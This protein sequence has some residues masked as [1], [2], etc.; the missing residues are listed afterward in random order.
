MPDPNLNARMKCIP[1][2]LW[3]VNTEYLVL[4]GYYDYD[5]SW[6]KLLTLPHIIYFKDMPDMEP[7]TARNKG[8]GETNILKFIIDFYDRLPK[9][10]INVH[11]YERK[12]YHKGSLVPYLNDA[13]G[14]LKRAYSQS[15]TLGYMGINNQPIAILHQMDPGS[16]KM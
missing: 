9:N 8:K 15:K 2:S 10:I 7:Y 4:I 16:K 1:Q 13:D 11:Q 3:D 12:F 6:V 5:V 14:S